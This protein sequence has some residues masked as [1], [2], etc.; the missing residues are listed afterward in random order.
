[1][2]TVHDGVE[3][4]EITTEQGWEIFDEAA[5]RELGMTGEAF[6]SAWDAGKLDDIAD[7]PDV[8]RVVMLLP[9]AR[10]R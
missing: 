3:V 4:Q 10:A 9:L 8:M 6:L 1:M 7:R 5:Q 2:T